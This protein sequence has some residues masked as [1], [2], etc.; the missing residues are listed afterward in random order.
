MLVSRSNPDIIGI[1]ETWLNDN[2][3]NN[4]IYIPGYNI[5]R[6]DRCNPTLNSGGGVLLYIR[7]N[8][9]AIESS[10]DCGGECEILWVKLHS[11]S[12]N[13]KRESFYIGICYRSEAISAAE[14]DVIYNSI[15]KHSQFHL[16]LMGDFNYS[17]IN[18]VQHSSGPLGKKF[19]K[20]VDDCF[21][22]Q[23]VLIP[24]RGMNILDLALTSEKNFV[25]DISSSS[26]LGKGD[27]NVIKWSTPN[28]EHNALTGKFQT[29]DYNKGDYH[30]FSTE[31]KQVPWPQVLL[32][33]TASESWNLLLGKINELKTKYIPL[34]TIVKARINAPWVNH[35]L[36]ERIKQKNNAWKRFMKD[37]DYN[38]KF[39]YNKLR[40]EVINEIRHCKREFE[41]KLAENIKQDPKSFYNYVNSKKLTKNVIG[42][43]EDSS[44]VL[45]EKDEEVCEILNDYF[46][47]VFT[48]EDQSGASNV[49]LVSSSAVNL[50]DFELTENI[51][52]NA[53][54]NVK[55]NKTAGVDDIP[56]NLII[57]IAEALVVPLTILF[58]I[59]LDSGDIPLDWRVANVT[60]IFKKGSKKLA[61]NYRPISLT[62][63]VVKIF[64]KIMKHEIS[65]HLLQY[66]LIKS[67][68]HGFREGK[69]CLTNLLEFF[70]SI[71]ECIDKGIP[72]D[73]VY[74]DF[75][76]AF[77]KVPHER[78]ISKLKSHSIS[79]KIQGW[80]SKW[81]EN[82]QQ[83]VVINGKNSSWSRVYSGVPQ[84]S[85][86]GPLLFSIYINDLDNKTTNKILKFADDTKVFGKV[87][88]K[89][90]IDS[91]H[92]DL[93]K[94]MQWSNDWLMPFNTDK[95]KV[96]HIGFNNPNVKYKLGS[97]EI[98]AVQEE[99]DLGII[100]SSDLK[101][102][103]QCIKASNTANKILGMIRRTISCKNAEIIIP[104]YKSLVRPHLEYCIQS[105]RPHL[106][107]DIKLLERV[108]K[109]ATKMIYENRNLNYS[110]RLL[111]C[112]LTSL[113][114]R[115][116]RAD[117]IEVFK[118][119]NE[120]EGLVKEDFFHF[121]PRISRGHRFKLTKCRSH[122]DARKFCFSNRIV[123]H[124]NNLPNNAVEAKSINVF[125]GRVDSYLSNFGGLI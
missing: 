28:L 41:T 104:L 33:K 22:I 43:I 52:Y 9:N 75:Q 116:I 96:L 80:I 95:C 124:W 78:L 83:R 13:K 121:N 23:N 108:Q 17:D 55:K 64:E 34:K 87:S 112:R 110:K 107:K 102:T 66:K 67:S 101:V 42:P 53:L 93:E 16:L 90:E 82:R 31:L 79:G 70:E 6:K 48:I 59:S 114:T 47:S 68:Q 65:K 115:R 89:A 39:K 71:T 117:L 46:S 84:G 4:E 54:L 19:L 18:W 1:T 92:N 119:V 15:R 85:V 105:W 26:P 7:D 125:K 86:L 30:G 99:K 44:G 60:A 40:N 77:D 109:R 72:V 106:H 57:G 37:K 5:F 98:K 118:I 62:S 103:K 58:R 36:K 111:K 27:H 69:S 21:L 2:I 74:L 32:N 25:S 97:N 12:I 51:V 91:L 123:E 35:S 61:S 113:E 122:L 20:L 45:R 8:I 3:Q 81:L 76:K 50:E 73:V 49:D 94:I 38:S 14:I 29:L 24:T 63:Q 56:S 11:S 100:V 88:K 10:E 120:F